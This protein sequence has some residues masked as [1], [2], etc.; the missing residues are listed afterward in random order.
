MAVAEKYIEEFYNDM[1]ALNV[2]RATIEPKA[3]EHIAQ[4]VQF[5]EKLILKGFAYRINGDVYYSVEKFNKYGKLS[6]RKL[7]DMK[8]RSE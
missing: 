8:F 1:D 6:G 5:I 7:K 2:Q 4:I 3:T